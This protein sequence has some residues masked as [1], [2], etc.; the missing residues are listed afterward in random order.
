MQCVWRSR[1]VASVPVVVTTL[2]LLCQKDFRKIQALNGKTVLGWNEITSPNSHYLLLFFSF[3]LFYLNDNHGLFLR[4]N[5]NGI[6][7]Y[8]K[9]FNIFPPRYA[10]RFSLH[11]FFAPKISPFNSL[12]SIIYLFFYFK[13]QNTQLNIRNINN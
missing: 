8:Y 11:V 7:N 1:W 5:L 10:S 6:F 2:N 13:F 4:F 9:I 12:Y 3:F